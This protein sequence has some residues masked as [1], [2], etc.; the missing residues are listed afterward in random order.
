MGSR[1]TLGQRRGRPVRRI[2]AN[3]ASP[4][5]KGKRL[6]ALRRAVSYDVRTRVMKRPTVATIGQRSK[7]IAYPGET[8]SPHAAYR[9]PPNPREMLAW[10]RQLRPGDLFVDI[11][12]NIGIY[13]VFALDLEAEVIACEPDPHNY[14][15]L[16]ENLQL[17]GYRAETHRA[18]VA[19]RPGTMR[20]TEGLD[21]YNHLVLDAAGAGIDVPAVTLDDLLGE[22]HAAGVKID[23]EGA[24]RL[25]IE[26]A[27]RSLAEKRIDLLQLEWS[28]LVARNTLGEGRDL[29]LELFAGA[30][31]DFFYV[32]DIKGRLHREDAA[33]E[34]SGKDVFVS[35]RP[36]ETP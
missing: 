2:V 34:M 18:A 17:N 29:L 36:I 30:G 15:R 21:S 13:S 4:A 31:Y 20:L 27:V 8:N 16:L 12:S 33:P 7:I 28:P 9:N 3:V 32:P 6:E 35:H 23:V 5:S 1:T 11:G 14:E 10:K 24:E 25:V 22:R 26:G 19:D